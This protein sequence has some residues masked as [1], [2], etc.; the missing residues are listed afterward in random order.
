MH[1][2]KVAKLFLALKDWLLV[3]AFIANQCQE[4]L[5]RYFK[6]MKTLARIG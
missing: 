4:F 2:K 1:L 5:A 3:G 6:V